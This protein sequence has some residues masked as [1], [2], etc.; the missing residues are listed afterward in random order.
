MIS[1]KCPQI[2]VKMGK[3]PK[4]KQIQTI[5]KKNLNYFNYSFRLNNFVLK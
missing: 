5:T 3:A 4:Q 2:R 1:Q